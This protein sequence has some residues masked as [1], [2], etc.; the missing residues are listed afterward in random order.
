MNKIRLDEFLKDSDVEGS[1]A[2]SR[3]TLLLVK[4]FAKDDCVGL[5]TIDRGRCTV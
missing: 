5:L 4:H 1:M 3:E 2:A